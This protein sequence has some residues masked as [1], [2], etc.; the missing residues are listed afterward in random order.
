MTDEKRIKA[1]RALSRYY[2]ERRKPAPSEDVAKIAGLMLEEDAKLRKDNRDMGTLGFVCAQVR[3][4]P[5]WVWAAQLFIVAAMVW[6]AAACGDVRPVRWAVGAMSAASVLVCVPTLLSGKQSGVIELEYAC[7]FNTARVLSARLLI[8]GCSCSL[9]VALMVAGTSAATGLGALT[10]ALWACPPYF[11]A[12]ATSIFA[13]RKLNTEVAALVSVAEAAVVCGALLVAS[14][15]FPG[16]YDT[17][18]LATWGLA[19]GAAAAWLA[20]EA[21]LSL[22][23]AARGLDSFSPHLSKYHG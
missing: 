19:T 10:V 14:E 20:R 13:L 4:V 9:A 23:S 16:I 18:A 1:E 21:V 15:V 5:A 11:L 2:A 17:A 22:R 3:F 12:C 6:T 8:L 7:R